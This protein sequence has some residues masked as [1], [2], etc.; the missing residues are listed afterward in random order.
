MRTWGSLAWPHVFLLAVWKGRRFEFLPLAHATGGG[1]KDVPAV[2][3][4]MA[5]T[6][7]FP[8]GSYMFEVDG[9]VQVATGYYETLHPGKP[10]LH[11]HGGPPFVLYDT[12]DWPW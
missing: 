3:T 6:P 8:K 10:S 5:P 9:V 2:E 12:T 7:E 4:Y 1:M 11:W